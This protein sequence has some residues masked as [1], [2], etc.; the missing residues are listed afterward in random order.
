MQITAQWA[1]DIDRIVAPGCDALGPGLYIVKPG[2]PKI[3]ADNPAAMWVPALGLWDDPKSGASRNDAR[4]TVVNGSRIYKR[5]RWG[6]R[7]ALPEL[8]M[9]QN[10]AGIKKAVTAYLKAL[11]PQHIGVDEA[12]ARL[13]ELGPE[14][15]NVPICLTARLLLAREG[16]LRAPGFEPTPHHTMS[17]T[18]TS[19]ATVVQTGRAKPMQARYSENKAVKVRSS[20]A[21]RECDCMHS[22]IC[23]CAWPSGVHAVGLS[24]MVDCACSKFRS[25]SAAGEGRRRRSYAWHGLT[26]GPQGRASGESR[27]RRDPHLCKLPRCRETSDS[28]VHS[29]ALHAPSTRVRRHM[30]TPLPMRCVMRESRCWRFAGRGEPSAQADRERRQVAGSH[31]QGE[32]PASRALAVRVGWLLRATCAAGRVC[33]NLRVIFHARYYKTQRFR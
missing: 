17:D 2:K 23:A 8:V 33:V 3:K 5:V 13:E 12:E 25:R 10:T 15:T 9:W 31:R 27:R 19:R 16:E 32:P 30:R 4:D 28:V 11:A 20:S 7:I 14:T 29:E 26:E 1:A 18:A 24:C 6:Q 22:S 21:M